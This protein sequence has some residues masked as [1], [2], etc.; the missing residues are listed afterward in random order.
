MKVIGWN[1]IQPNRLIYNVT[2]LENFSQIF[3]VANGFRVLRRSAFSALVGHWQA[4]WLS[5][6]KGAWKIIGFLSDSHSELL[7]KAGWVG[8]VQARFFVSKPQEGTPIELRW[9]VRIRVGRPDGRPSRCLLADFAAAESDFL[10]A[11]GSAR[12]PNPLFDLWQKRQIRRQ[13]QE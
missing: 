13:R 2:C 12:Q 10:V 3:Q 1:I 8:A 7:R 4:P 6:D 9:I 11:T 5:C